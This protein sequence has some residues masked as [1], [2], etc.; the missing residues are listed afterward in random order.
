[1]RYYLKFFLIVCPTS[2]I[3]HWCSEIDTH[4]DRSVELKVRVHQ[5]GM[6]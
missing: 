4:V 5:D 3:S 1:M 2:L 6:S